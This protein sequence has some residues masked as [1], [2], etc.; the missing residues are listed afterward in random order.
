VYPVDDRLFR[1]EDDARAEAERVRHPWLGGVD[2]GDP[3]VRGQGDIAGIAITKPLPRLQ[4]SHSVPFRQEDD[5][6]GHSN[7][8]LSG[9]P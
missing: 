2:L 8:P 1:A 5:C 9:C 3:A 7:A 4:F 6:A